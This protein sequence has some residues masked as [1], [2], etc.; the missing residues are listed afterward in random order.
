MNHKAYKKI[1]GNFK[2]MKRIN[3]FF[4]LTLSAIV[5]ST[6]FLSTARSQGPPSGDEDIQYFYQDLVVGKG[7]VM[8]LEDE[9]L[10]MNGAVRIE[11]TLILK[12]SALYMNS[13]YNGEYGIKVQPTGELVIMDNSRIEPYGKKH[14]TLCVLKDKQDH[15]ILTIQD[16]TVSGAGYYSTYIEHNGIYIESKKVTISRSIISDNHEG[17]IFNSVSGEVLVE[18]SKFIGN[19][20]A[21]VMDGSSDITIRGNDFQFNQRAI[22][23]SESGYFDIVKNTFFDNDHALKVDN[24]SDFTIRENTFKG[25]RYSGIHLE[26]S[27]D[28][29][30]EDNQI[31][32]TRS[33]KPDMLGTG[34]TLRGNSMTTLVDNTLLYNDIGIM[35][36]HNNSGLFMNNTGIRG[37][38]LGLYYYDEHFTNV[39]QNMRITETKEAAITMKHSTNQVLNDMDLTSNLKNELNVTSSSVEFTFPEFDKLDYFVG[40]KSI[41]SISS[42]IRVHTMDLS[43]L[44]LQGSEVRITNEGEKIY[45]TPGYGGNDPITDEMGMT[46]WL[47]KEYIIIDRWGITQCRID[48]SVTWMGLESVRTSFGEIEEV[49]RF[50]LRIPD[51]TISGTDMIIL[52]GEPSDDEVST[53][54]STVTNVGT[55][56]VS[57]DVSVYRVL[58]IWDGDVDIPMDTFSLPSTAELIESVAVTVRGKEKKTLE[59]EWLPGMAGQYTIFTIIDQDMETLELREDNNIAYTHVSVLQGEADPVKHA[60]MSLEVPES[61]KESNVS[62]TEL[63]MTL[64]LRNVGQTIGTVILMGTKTQNDETILFFTDVY[65]VGAGG[66]LRLQVPVD[67]KP[68]DVEI[69]FTMIQQIGENTLEILTPYVAF[70]LHVMEEPTFQLLANDDPLIPGVILTSTVAGSIAFIVAFVAFAESVRYRFLLLF[71]PLYMRMSKK[72]IVE[73]YTRGEILGYIKQNPGESY[74]NIKRDLEMSNGKLAYHLSVLEK[75]GFL[76]SVTDGMYRRY[77]P[78]KMKVTTYGRITSVQEEILR[79][80]EETPA[81]TQKDL[82]KLVS[83]STATINYH[84]RKLTNK[85]LITSSRTGIFVHYSLNGLT[86][87]EIMANAISGS[88]RAVV[89]Q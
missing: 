54:A 12:H 79:R 38:K 41:V 71:V 33:Q 44:P 82:S 10:V 48:I 58:G 3:L 51:L 43:G 88:R 75:G 9:I 23:V 28:G 34:I 5:V 69:N 31:A 15:G 53:I 65:T 81:I 20:K 13:S 78:K 62:S 18:D 70:N 80:I 21:L 74:N 66:E 8:T 83:L 40:Q 11:G 89:K 19:E 45:A 63:T 60:I 24:S 46:D 52:P 1:N 61:L 76:K 57:T 56:S 67:L 22:E 14:Y 30:I 47:P 64:T 73:H 36:I 17:L 25:N 7:S 55:S 35:M 27:Q 42:R 84:I 72:D 29:D 68:G 37:G 50:Y 2:T 4:I 16:S 87:E 49:V 85:G 86:V 6:I 39:Y 32:E 26:F 59:V 77:Y